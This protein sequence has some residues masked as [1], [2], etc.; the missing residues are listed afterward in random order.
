MLNPIRQLFS[1]CVS[2]KPTNDHAIVRHFIIFPLLYLVSVGASAEKIFRY[3]DPLTGNVTLSNVS[4]R[5]RAST[6]VAALTHRVAPTRVSYRPASNASTST[7]PADFPRVTT[8]QQRDRDN[9]RRQILIDELKAEQEAFDQASAR[10]ASD[11]EIHFHR[12][13]IAALERELQRTQ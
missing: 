4:L 12:A 8:A 3:V 1:C 10:N 13:N 11:D 7:S 5:S 2:P 9:D 6:R